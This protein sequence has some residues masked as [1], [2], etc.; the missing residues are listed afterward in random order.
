MASIHNLGWH[1][2]E[3]Q[4]EG[5]TMMGMFLAW[6]L[7]R[8]LGSDE[9]REELGPEAPDRSEPPSH[10][11]SGEKFGAE[12]LTAEGAAFAQHYW[13]GPYVEDFFDHVLEKAGLFTRADSWKSFDRLATVMDARLAEWRATRS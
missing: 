11:A 12:Q 13:D 2:P 5:A 7:L 8:G 3:S 10:L 4:A 1:P 6:V 9:L